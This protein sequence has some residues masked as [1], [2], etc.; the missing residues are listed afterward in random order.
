MDNLPIYRYHQKMMF[1]LAMFEHHWIPI[2]SPCFN[3]ATKIPWYPMIQCMN[4]YI[5]IYIFSFWLDNAG[6]SYILSPIS[7]YNPLNPI[8][9]IYTW[10][11]CSHIPMK[12]LIFLCQE[13][14]PLP[15]P[16]P[17]PRPPPCPAPQRAAR[18]AAVRPRR[19]REAPAPWR[20]DEKEPTCKRKKSWFS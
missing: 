11:L 4:I 10:M 9:Y 19:W 2:K 13:T 5:Y 15:A 17:T 20:R 12:S 18:T 6:I 7:Y 1:N 3:F 14:P 16:A 8:I